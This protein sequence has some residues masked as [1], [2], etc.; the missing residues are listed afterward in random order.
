MG[1]IISYPIIDLK[2]QNRLKVGTDK[3]KLSR[4][5]QYQMPADLIAKRCRMAVVSS[6]ADAL[7][8]LVVFN[9]LG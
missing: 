8:C 1:H 4:R 5:S 7:C 2:R 3:S 9:Y 6:E